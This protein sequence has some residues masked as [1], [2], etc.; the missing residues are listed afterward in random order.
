MP[1]RQNSSNSR[2]L[3]NYLNKILR[4]DAVALRKMIAD[5]ETKETI[6]AKKEKNARRCL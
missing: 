1:E 5:G 6:Q 4:K 2:E 3:N